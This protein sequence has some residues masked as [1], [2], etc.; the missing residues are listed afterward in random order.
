[1]DLGFSRVAVVMAIGDYVGNL[2]SVRCLIGQIWRVCKEQKGL[3]SN[4]TQIL[5]A[6]ISL[7][8]K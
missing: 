7:T 3:V 8:M 4:L 5:A 6:E 1:M 2:L